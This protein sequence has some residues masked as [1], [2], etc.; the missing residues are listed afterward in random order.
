MGDFTEFTLPK[1]D[2]EVEILNSCLIILIQKGQLL[3]KDICALSNGDESLSKRIKYCLIETGAAKESPNITIRVLPTEYAA[4]YLETDYYASIH[5]E[6]V[7]KEEKRNLELIKLKE[8]IANLKR[9]KWMS[10]TALILSVISLFKEY[11]LD[12]FYK[13]F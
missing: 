8:D 9:Q 2:D 11:I 12:I 6:K 3:D 5:K 10:K 13:V 4:K 1:S 7:E